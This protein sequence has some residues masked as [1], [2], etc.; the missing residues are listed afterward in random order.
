MIYMYS[1]LRLL[2]GVEACDMQSIFILAQ[3]FPF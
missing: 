2:Y 1:G 3:I